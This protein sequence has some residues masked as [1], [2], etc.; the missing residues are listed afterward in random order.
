VPAGTALAVVEVLGE[1]G[2]GTGAAGG[3]G[4]ISLGAAPAGS[5]AAVGWQNG[6]TLVQTGPTQLVARGASV[7]LG[8]P[9]ATPGWGRKASYG[10][11]GAAAAMASQ[12]A[13][14]TRLPLA[15]GV[16]IIVLDATGEAGAA[17]GDLAVAVTGA[18]L[19][20][21]PLRIAGANRRLLL[22]DVSARDQKAGAIT[23]AVASTAAWTLTGVIGVAGTAAAWAS[24]L[25]NGLPA[26]FVPEGP[27]TPEGSITM[28]WK[29]AAK[30]AVA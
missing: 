22:Y 11:I 17:E 8:R 28:I 29:P 4:T 5:A 19:A 7:R 10:A 21:P 20:T 3:F 2:A 6:S 14:E 18:T 27:L 24:A 30:E 23:V 26:E 25:A 1:P 9:T 16:V 12:T 13:V 15:I